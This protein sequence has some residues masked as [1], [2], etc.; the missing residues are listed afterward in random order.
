MPICRIKV[1]ALWLHARRLY[2]ALLPYDASYIHLITSQETLSNDQTGGRWIV[3]RNIQFNY[4][5]ICATYFIR[6]AIIIV[7]C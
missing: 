1:K 7:C 4:T 5:C 3:S 2:T 6:K